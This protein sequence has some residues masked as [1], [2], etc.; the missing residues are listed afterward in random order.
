MQ[1][2]GMFTDCVPPESCASPVQLHRSGREN[3]DREWFP[4]SLGTPGS[5]YGASLSAQSR[6]RTKP[7]VSA[8]EATRDCRISTAAIN[9]FANHYLTVRVE[10]PG[11]IASKLHGPS[12]SG[13]KDVTFI[14][15]RW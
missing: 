6:Q 5:L 1:S 12:Q 14:E 13:S 7:Q 11:I 3:P 15:S 8:P 4:G 10:S 2:V 9:G